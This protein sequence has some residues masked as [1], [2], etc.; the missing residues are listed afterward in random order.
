MPTVLVVEDGEDYRELLTELLR[1]DGWNV[2]VAAHSRAAIEVAQWS[3]V[4]VVL[5]DIHLRGESGQALEERFKSINGL[6]SIPFVF[7]SGSKRHLDA[8]P[9]GRAIR[10]PFAVAELDRVLRAAIDAAIAK[11]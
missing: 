5:T 1:L 4:D 11:S 10:K 7:M 3:T 2:F 8:V 9:H 6:A